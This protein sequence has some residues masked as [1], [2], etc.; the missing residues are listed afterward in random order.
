MIIPDDNYVT[1]RGYDYFSDFG[2]IRFKNPVL[3]LD[4]TS[5]FASNKKL[6]YV[7]LPN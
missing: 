5:V 1:E 7:M 2:Y 4:G 3:H 6:T